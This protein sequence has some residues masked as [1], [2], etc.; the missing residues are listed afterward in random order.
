[1]RL[2]INNYKFIHKVTTFF[3][4]GVIE[5]FYIHLPTCIVVATC[6]QSSIGIAFEVPNLILINFPTSVLILLIRL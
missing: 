4:K 1:M 5:N 2:T 3:P 6:L